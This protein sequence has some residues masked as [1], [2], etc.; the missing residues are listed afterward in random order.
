MIHTDCGVF[1][2]F[3]PIMVWSLHAV[4]ST[5]EWAASTYLEKSELPR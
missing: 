3:R 4:P 2:A 5:V 1:S